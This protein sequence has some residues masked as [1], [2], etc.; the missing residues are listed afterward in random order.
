MR[1]SLAVT[2]LVALTIAAI[3]YVGSRPRVPPPFG[4]ARS[5]V[6]AVDLHQDIGTIEPDGTRLRMLTFGPALDSHPTFSPDGRRI[7]YLSE[8]AGLSSA[9]S[10]MDADGRNP[11]TLAEGL[12]GTLDNVLNSAYAIA[13]SWAPDSRHIAVAARIGDDAQSR[14]YVVAIDRPGATELGG[15]GV[16]GMSPSW[17]PDGSLIAFK[18]TYPCCAGPP[19]S[20]WLMGA[21]GT[22]PHQ[23]SPRGGTDEGVTR[24]AWSPDGTRVAFVAPG[25][26]LNDD[27]FVIGVDGKGELNLTNSPDD[28][29]WPSWSPDGTRLAFTRVSL[30]TDL[31]A[32]PGVFMIDADGSHQMTI[33]DASVGVTT[34]VWSPDGTRILG[35]DEGLGGGRSNNFVII[36]PTGE[37]TPTTIPVTDISG[38]TWQRLAP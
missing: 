27:V 16:Y 25:K 28:E 35:I 37:V 32:R 22:N 7:A 38:A 21:D 1:V 24:P 8:D 29:L 12:G 15:P 36:D 11:I 14:I 19:P 3:A 33:A 5:G 30:G 18:R 34:V 2:L 10:V 17:S 4:P 23:L 20:L 13:L 26:Q 6:I 31:S 9:L